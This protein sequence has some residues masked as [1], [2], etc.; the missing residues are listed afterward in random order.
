[1]RI[2]CDMVDWQRY[3]AAN[4][5]VDIKQPEQIFSGICEGADVQ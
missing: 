4:P 2:T 5:G 1:M 3:A